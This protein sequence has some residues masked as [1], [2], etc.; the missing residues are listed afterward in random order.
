MS[1]LSAT[2]EVAPVG[3]GSR[4]VKSCLRRQDSKSRPWAWGADA[5]TDFS[6]NGKGVAPVRAWGAVETIPPRRAGRGLRMFPGCI[7]MGPAIAP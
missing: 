3:V 7:W 2:A 5:R 6:Q 4:A 1:L